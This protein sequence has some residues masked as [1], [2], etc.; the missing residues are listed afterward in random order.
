MIRRGRKRK[1]GDE[2][3]Q[4]GMV[5]CWRCVERKGSGEWIWA[6][7]CEEGERLVGCLAEDGQV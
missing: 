1:K 4:N 5:W 7:D 2:R 3:K 6:V